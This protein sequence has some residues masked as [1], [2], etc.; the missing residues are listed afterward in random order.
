MERWDVY[1]RAGNPLGRT[2]AR[3][4]RLRD[5]EHHLVVHVWVV[6]SV[7]RLLIQRRSPRRQMMP[8]MWAAT[9]GSAVAGE[10]SL[11]AIRRELREEM[12]ICPKKEEFV[13]AGRLV[14]RN[15]LCDVWVV[16][17]DVAVPDM[18]LQK[19]EVSDARYVTPDQLRA[20]VADGR[21]HDYGAPYFRLLMKA[22]ERKADDQC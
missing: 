2:V 20:M 3:G 4:E 10:D 12:G 9:G 7:G 16:R 5:G 8:N 14:R 11:T 22:V 18:K 13:L 17:K 21:F 1:D 15:S 6:N 19:S